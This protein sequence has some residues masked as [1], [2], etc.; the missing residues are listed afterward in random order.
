MWMR[1]VP[2]A[3]LTPVRVP[4]PVSAALGITTA[5]TIVVGIF[6]NLFAHLGDLANFTSALGR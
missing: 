2:D 4:V 5:V 3:D 1:P 6:P